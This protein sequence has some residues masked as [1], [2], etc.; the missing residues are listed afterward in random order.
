MK[1]ILAFAVTF[2]I[3]TAFCISAYASDASAQSVAVPNTD[4][5]YAVCLYNVNTQKSIYSKNMQ[6]RIF[7]AG[8]VKMMTGLMA[9]Q[10]LQDRLDEQITITED[11]LDGVKGNSMRLKAGMSVTLENLLYGV[12]CAGGN[13][14]AAVVSIAC[15][16][17]I[18][19]FV[20]AMNSKAKEW[21]LENTFFTN[22]TGL[23]DKNMYSTL[24]DIMIIAQKAY[25]NKLYLDISSAMSYVFTPIGE[26]E[27]IKIFNRNALISTFYATGYRNPNCM[28]LISGNTDLGGDCVITYAQKKDT[29]YICAVM[30]AQ[31]DDEV[32]YSYEI[33]NALLKYAFENFY[34]QLN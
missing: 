1:K 21:G 6:K 23:D 34:Y 26:N 27:E 8:A 20:D 22:P 14:A 2:F 15:M 33:T 29:G 25:E 3:L 31:A 11:M 24:S 4:K 28:G 32:I 30:K 5:A 10:I 17:S 9:C 13:D 19:A 7:P 18:D 16:G 12:L